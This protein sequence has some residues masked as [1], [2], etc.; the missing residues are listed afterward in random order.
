AV[1]REAFDEAPRRDPDKERRWGVL[2]DGDPKQVRAVQ[3]EARRVGVKVTRSAD[4]AR[5]VG[6]TRDAARALVGGGQ[7]EAERRVADRPLAL[8]SGPSGGDV[9]KTIRGGEARTEDLDASAH[10]TRRRTCTYLADRTGTRML[11]YQ[12]ALG[13]GLP[14]ATG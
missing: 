6:Y 1:I 11:G 14:I 12:E 4:S 8:L 9:A 10:A 7:C 5:V 3:A 13:D 2:V